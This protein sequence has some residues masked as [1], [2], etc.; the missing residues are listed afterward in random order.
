MRVGNRPE[1][2]QIIWI[3][4]S[5]LEAESTCHS[6]KKNE[7]THET[8]SEQTL[9]NKNCGFFFFLLSEN[10]ACFPLHLLQFSQCWTGNGSSPDVVRLTNNRP[11]L[12]ISQKI[13]KRFLLLCLSPPSDQW[14][15]VLGFV[16]AGNVQS[17]STLQIIQAQNQCICNTVF[18][19]CNCIQ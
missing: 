15:D 14:Y 19:H 2:F 3:K 18:I 11:C 1:V 7:Q 16:F 10:P 9:R 12:N 5:F 13:V 6:K 8:Y 17:S 4:R